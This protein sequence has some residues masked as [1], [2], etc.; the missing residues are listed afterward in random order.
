M[1]KLNDLEIVE[2]LKQALRETVAEK[3]IVCGFLSRTNEVLFD[4]LAQIKALR[5]ENDALKSL[6]FW[7]KRN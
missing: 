2:A 5:M 4:K 1:T 6:I 3:D 7:G